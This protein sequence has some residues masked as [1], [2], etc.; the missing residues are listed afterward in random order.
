M[1][2]DDQDLDAL[3]RLGTLADADAPAAAPPAWRPHAP[4]PSLAKRKGPRRRRALALVAASAA[5]LGGGIATA[6]IL[7]GDG[8][9]RE[10]IESFARDARISESAARSSLIAQGRAPDLASAARRAAPDA[11]G[12]LWIERTRIKVGLTARA[13][14]P[15]RTT[16]R[17][18]AE[19]L[20][21]AAFVDVV[22][23]E[24]SERQLLAIQRELERGAA[25]V[26][27]DAETTIDIEPDVRR[28]VVTVAL[29][30]A[31][32]RATP[33]QVAFVERVREQH[34]TTIRVVA[35]TSQL[36]RDVAVPA[37]K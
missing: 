34:G 23:V 24:R 37:R 6:S 17:Q 22:E 35:K 36:H 2:S 16:I 20:G 32:L 33:A 5:V 12:G 10:E 19:R 26:N 1:S 25:A 9:A 11:F 18:D 21:I 30:S 8:P 31:P 27:R 4:S 14:A 7:G 15:A 3:R 13:S 29:P 28:S